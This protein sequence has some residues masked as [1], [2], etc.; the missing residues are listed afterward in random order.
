MQ[1]NYTSLGLMTGTSREGVDASL[2]KS[3][4]I[5]KFHTIK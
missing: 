3:N 4:G 5:E 2:A 1:K